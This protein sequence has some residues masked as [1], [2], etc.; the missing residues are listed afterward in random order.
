MNFTWKL[1]LGF[2][3]TYSL[4]WISYDRNHQ[5][6]IYQ[7]SVQ[8]IIILITSIVSGNM[9]LHDNAIITVTKILNAYVLD[10]HMNHFIPYL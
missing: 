2:I 5:L 1:V 4:H 3:A 7:I 6:R 10:I 8:V 9:P